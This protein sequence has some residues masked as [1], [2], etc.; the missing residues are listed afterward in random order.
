MA[1]TPEWVSDAVFYQVFPDRFARSDRLPTRKNFEPWDAP[2]SREGFK[3][4]DLFGLI[5]RLDELQD[6]GVTALYLNPIFAAASNHRYH[7]YDYLQVDPLLGGDDAFE[8]LM[9]ALEE[10]SM[11]VILDGVF[12][13]TG[14][15]FWAF[16]HILESG[17]HSPYVDWYKVESFPLQT[18]GPRGSANYEC[19]W[20]LPA[21]P[22]LNISNPETREYL[23]EVAEHWIDRGAHG[24]R[25][26]VPN[27][28]DDPEFWSSFRRRVR[29]KDPAAYLVGEIWK[30]GP[31]WVAG[32]R[33]D[34]L[35][36][37]P[38]TR[39]ILGYVGGD[40][41]D[42]KGLGNLE[43]QPLDAAGA[44]AELNPPRRD[45]TPRRTSPGLRGGL[46]GAP[47]VRPRR[48]APG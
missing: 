48:G 23:L 32:D 37:Y 10:R 7:T 3:G 8:A 41:L 13:H 1:D 25:L 18:Y 27:E 12:N 39:W 36:N 16:H 26:D 38:L 24:W 30:D 28:I 43:V 21:L 22:K 6:L 35:M 2:P 34:G 14:R 11:R 47:G 44:R 31:E 29:R 17:S 9:R 5:E 4:G 40:G 42:P 33:F 46:R 45:G 19:W 15:G 20:D